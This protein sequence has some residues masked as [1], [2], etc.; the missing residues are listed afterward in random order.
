MKIKY[1]KLKHWLLV[2][3]GG[4]LGFSFAGCDD[5]P[6]GTEKYGCPEATYHVKGTVTN[7]KGD[8]IEG[9][10]VAQAYDSAGVRYV[11]LEHSGLGTTNPDGRYNVSL[12]GMPGQEVAIGFRDIDGD[13][14]GR[15]RD[16]VITVSAPRED[17][18][19]GDGEWNY[20]T[21]EITQDVVMRPATENK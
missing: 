16:T 20:G 19:G 6:Y 17:F 14:N 11:M 18:H 21:A 7:E 5:F 1:L 10:E 3:L 13:L 4:L 9:I 15:Y 12:Y 2:S 8:P